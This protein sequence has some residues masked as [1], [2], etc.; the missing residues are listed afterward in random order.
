MVFFDYNHQC[1][2]GQENQMVSICRIRQHAR[3]GQ[4]QVIY[5]SFV[6][7]CFFYVIWLHRNLILSMLSLLSHEEHLSFNRP[8]VRSRS[9]FEDIYFFNRYVA[10]GWTWKAHEYLLGWGNH[11]RK[12]NCNQTSFRQLNFRNYFSVKK[13]FLKRIVVIFH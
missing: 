13:I 6:S 5:S 9:F 10:L 12:N 1:M 11:S 8:I 2:H 4:D 7:V 3:Y